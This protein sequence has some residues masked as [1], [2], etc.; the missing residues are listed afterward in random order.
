MRFDES[1]T[2]RLKHYL[3]SFCTVIM[4]GIRAAYK[5]PG[6]I[7]TER[8]VITIM[9]KFLKGRMCLH[10]PASGHRRLTG[11]GKI[12][13]E[14][15]IDE[16]ELQELIEAYT[17]VEWSKRGS[18]FL[19]GVMEYI[20]KEM[21]CAVRRKTTDKEVS[22]FIL[23]KAISADTDMRNLFQEVFRHLLDANE[24]SEE[25]VRATY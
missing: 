24:C 16:D 25:D 17:C 2:E 22:D 5:R 11:G 6:D 3:L 1:G 10:A 13:E 4:E 14:N 20:L 18:T 8:R 7:I 9:K 15:C 23:Q 21:L 19:A 12:D